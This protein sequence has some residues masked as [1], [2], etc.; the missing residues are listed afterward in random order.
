MSGV[1]EAPGPLFGL[2]VVELASEHAAFAGK[3]LGDLG[4]DVIV[5]EPPGGHASRA[6][7]PFAD[8]VADPERSL[9]WWHY[10]TVEARVVLDLDAARRRALPPPRRR[11]RHRPRGRATRRARHPALDHPDLRADNE[12]LIWVS[13]TPFGAPVRAP[14]SPPPTSRCWPAAGRCG[15]AATTTTRCRRCAAAATRRSTSLCTSR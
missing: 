15:A 2:R 9:W 13:V 7:G 4:A 10:N 14:R 8:D 3:M 1:A 11:G 12:E 5:V 6:V